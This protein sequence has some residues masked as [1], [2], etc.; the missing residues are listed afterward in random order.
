M[1]NDT[2][3][4]GIGSSA[5]LGPVLSESEVAA[6]KDGERVSVVWSGGNG[7]HKYEIGITRSGQ[8]AV[9]HR[10]RG[11]GPDAGKVYRM[12]VLDFIGTKAPRTTVRRVLPNSE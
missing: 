8:V 5:W 3:T 2:E 12:T 7:P 4:V 10:L 1:K 9:K 11:I 6:L